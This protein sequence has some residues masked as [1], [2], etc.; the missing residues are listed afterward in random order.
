MV[1]YV[2]NLDRRPERWQYVRDHL[3]MMGISPIRFSA[4]DA[5]P[6][7]HGCRD[8]HLAILNKMA[9]DDVIAVYEDDVKF[10]EVWNTVLKS[11]SQLPIGWDCLYLGAS[12]KEPQKQVSENI[13]RLKN[14]HVAHAIIWRRREG[15][16]VDYILDHQVEIKKIDDYYANV[17]QPKFNCFV[18][19][20]MVATQVQFKS[21]T[22]YRSDVSTILKNYTKYITT[23]AKSN[24]TV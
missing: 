8:S 20:P 3:Y 1:S 5:K 12:P 24:T 15:G 18:C 22:C 19:Y 4:I 11:I 16:A 23:Y 9:I 14:A 10:I 17:I 13:F 7:W 21:D 6:G 2:V